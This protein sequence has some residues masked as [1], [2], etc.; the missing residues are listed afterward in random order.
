M[1]PHT[2]YN[3]LC[4]CA[5]RVS[6]SQLCIN[7]PAGLRVCACAIRCRYGYDRDGFSKNKDG[8]WVNPLG[9]LRVE[10]SNVLRHKD[11]YAKG[12]FDKYGFDEHGYN[13]EGYDKYGYNKFGYDKDGRDVAGFDHKGVNK[14]GQPRFAVYTPTKDEAA[15][16]TNCTKVRVVGGMGLCTCIHMGY[17]QSGQ[18]Q[19]SAVC[20]ATKMNR[21]GLDSQIPQPLAVGGGLWAEDCTGPYQPDHV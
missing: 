14:E 9:Y 4:T 17:R 18:Q 11:G 15:A 2:G 7:C 3:L 19:L 12:G 5:T 16:G 20:P 13:K 10:G 8:L 21:L 6:D 1:R